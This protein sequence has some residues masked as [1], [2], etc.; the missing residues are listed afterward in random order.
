MRKRLESSGD[1]LEMVS[2]SRSEHQSQSWRPD[3]SL[4]MKDGN[5]SVRAGSKGKALPVSK[6]ANV[7]SELKSQ[8]L[9][10]VS[11][12]LLRTKILEICCDFKESI[13]SERAG[14]D[15]A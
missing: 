2:R 9:Q 13:L 3:S 11:L 6:E 8:K 10:V 4:P 15:L 14:Q 7:T 1:S 5:Y 12:M